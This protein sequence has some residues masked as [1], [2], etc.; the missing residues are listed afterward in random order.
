MAIVAWNVTHL[1]RPSTNAESKCD[2]NE[3]KYGCT[4]ARTTEP[5][6]CEISTEIYSELGG[7]G[8]VS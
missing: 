3:R 5:V 7:S 1:T 6:R 4:Y 2:H 8:G